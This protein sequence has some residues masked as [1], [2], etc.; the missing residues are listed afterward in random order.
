MKKYLKKIFVPFKLAY[1]KMNDFIKSNLRRGR[2]FYIKHRERIQ[3]IKSYF[4]IGVFWSTL[5]ILL[6]L[7]FAHIY[8]NFK[9][10]YDIAEYFRSCMEYVLAFYFFVF[11]I[12]RYYAPR[13]LDPMPY[14]YNTLYKIEIND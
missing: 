3:N 13:R 10:F 4:E 12:L 2:N 11:G 6:L 7:F 5:F 8:K 1:N 14:F 9:I